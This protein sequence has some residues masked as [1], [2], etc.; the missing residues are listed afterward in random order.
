MEE[1]DRPHWTLSL[2]DAHAKIDPGFDHKFG[3]AIQLQSLILTIIK[4]LSVLNAPTEEEILG[5]NARDEFVQNPKN[6][7]W[8]PSQVEYDVQSL[9]T[10]T[11]DLYGQIPEFSFIHSKLKARY[12]TPPKEDL[13]LKKQPT[14]TYISQE[15]RKKLEEDLAKAQKDSSDEGSGFDEGYD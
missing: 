3:V 6:I 7:I 11:I 12:I 8:Q 2:I 9:T 4:Q 5:E 1:D 15:Q 14:S 10:Q 13:G